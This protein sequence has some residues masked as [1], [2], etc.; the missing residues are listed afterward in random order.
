MGTAAGCTENQVPLQECC[1]VDSSGHPKTGGKPEF[2]SKCNKSA[3]SLGVVAG[4]VVIF[5]L[6][7]TVIV[8]TVPRAMPPSAVLGS[9]VLLCCPHGWV[10]YKGKCYY[11]SEGEGNW[12]DS[13]SHCSALGASLAGINTLQEMAFMH[14]YKGKPDHWIG[15]Q[16]DPE[17]PWKWANGS[18]FNNLFGIRGGGDCA[19]LNDESGVSS[20]RCTN[21]R[22]WIC[23]KPDAFPTSEPRATTPASAF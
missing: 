23:T 2:C 12:T 13:W 11:F 10:G 15:L 1:S 19:Y 16:R 6:L 21:E 8:Q 4:V 20:S 3:V 14:R 7:I 18:K 5:G 9:P 17:Q 22:R